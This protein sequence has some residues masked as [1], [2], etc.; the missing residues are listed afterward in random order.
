MGNVGI[1]DGVR[2]LIRFQTGLGRV[3]DLIGAVCEDVIPG[4]ISVGLGPV[5]LIPL[6]IGLAG[7]ID[8]DDDPAIA[9]AFV[10]DELSDFEPWRF[11][12]GWRRRITQQLSNPGSLRGCG[13]GIEVVEL[14]FEFGTVL[15][16]GAGNG[17]P[18]R[19]GRIVEE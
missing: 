17:R 9:V 8:V 12:R 10:A 4:L 18:Y 2:F 16:E 3:V 19:F 13:C 1:L 15:P 7:V 6:L 11:R 5:S 14:R